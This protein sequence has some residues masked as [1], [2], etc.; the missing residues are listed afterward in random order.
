MGEV[1]YNASSDRKLA[2]REL[3]FL[4]DLFI[5]ITF[6]SPQFR[7]VCVSSD[8]V[9]PTEDSSCLHKLESVRYP[10]YSC[11]AGLGC[12]NFEMFRRFV[13]ALLLL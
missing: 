11:S 13:T 1:N 8:G 4:G 6:R 7:L 12:L 10:S 9:W 2:D 3:D 5:Y